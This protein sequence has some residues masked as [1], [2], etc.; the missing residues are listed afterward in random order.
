M[1]PVLVLI[2]LHNTA[3]NQIVLNTNEVVSMREGDGD[4]QRVT[5][6]IRCIINT[7]DGKFISVVEECHD[8]IEAAKESPK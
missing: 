1:I 5:K 2:I 7:T 8:I 3:G 6:G 4:N